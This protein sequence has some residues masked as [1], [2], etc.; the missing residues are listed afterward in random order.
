MELIRG[1]LR[2]NCGAKVAQETRIL[3]G[4]PITETNAENI[5][6][7]KDVDGFLI[8]TTSTKPAFRPIFEIVHAQAQKDSKK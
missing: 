8:G 2:D 1:W 4:G 7:L 5:I 6:K 3:Y